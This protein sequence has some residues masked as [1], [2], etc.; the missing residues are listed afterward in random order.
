M[1]GTTFYS[2]LD[3]TERILA[4]GRPLA[5]REFVEL[6]TKEQ[7]EPHNARLIE[8]GKLIPLEYNEQNLEQLRGAA[9]ALD[10]Q[11]RS[12]MNKDELE[13]AIREKRALEVPA[14]AEEVT[15]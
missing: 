6:S 4:D 11:G 15:P 9:A 8:E 1:S 13:Q 12:N 5:P 2:P 7:R 3:A 10:I 14:L